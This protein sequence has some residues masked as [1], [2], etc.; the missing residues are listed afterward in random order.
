MSLVV[1]LTKAR[2]GIGLTLSKVRRRVFWAQQTNPASRQPDFT[3]TF[4]QHPD[5]HFTIKMY[6]ESC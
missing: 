6:N 1:V 3:F 5:Q 4:R 2:R